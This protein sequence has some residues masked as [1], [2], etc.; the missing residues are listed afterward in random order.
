MNIRHLLALAATG[1]TLTIAACGGGGIEGTGTSANGTMRLAITDAPACGYDALHVTVEKV[2]V[3]KNSE[4]GDGDGGWSEVV[5]SPARRIELLAL[6]NGVLDNLGQTALPAGKYNQMR[7]VL[8]AN[9]GAT[10]LANSVTPTGGTETALTTPS[11]Q[12]SGIKL[13]VDIDIPANQI[14]DFVIDFD[15]CKSV[16]RRGNSGQFNL[17]PVISVI[18][19]VSDA[20]MRVVGYV[21]PAMAA[22]GTGVSVQ[23]GGVPVRS[24]VPAADGRFVLYPVPAGTYDLVVNSSGR[25]TAVMTGVP[26]VNTAF[27]IVSSVSQPIVP[28]AATTRAVTGTVTPVDATVRALR[29]LTGGPTVEVAW[30]NVDAL[31]GSFGFTLPIE[32]PVRANYSAVGTSVFTADAPVAGRYT[33]TAALG[34]A[35]KTQAID[36]AQPVPPVVFSFP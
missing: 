28:P 7:L 24:T 19:V 23:A 8:A 33:L 1:T 30:G 34:T 25:V 20:G 2:R 11:G 18:P 36:I 17:K 32:A 3:H 5:L 12:Q 29:A 16:V 22:A 9:G 21:S 13:K 31:N 35:V 26:V 14:A 15:A 27:T 10:P 4:A 6:T